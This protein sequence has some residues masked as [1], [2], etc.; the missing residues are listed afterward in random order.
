MTIDQHPDACALLV[1]GLSVRYGGFQAVEGLDLTVPTGAV[2]GL[3]GPNGAGKTSCF[4]AICGHV[5]ANAGTVTV[6]GKNLDLKSPRT[7]WLA[8]IG[9]TFQRVELFW[10]LSVR[11]HLELAIRHAEKLGR[12]PPPIEELISVVGL[13][14][15]EETLAANLPLGTCRLLELARALATGARL[16]LLDE[17]CSGLDRQETSELEAALRSIKSKIELS[18]LIVE[19]DTEFIFSIADVIFVL[20]NGRLIAHGTPGQIRSSDVVRAAY[21]GVSDEPV[22]SGVAS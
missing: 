7:A 15:L 3:I 14:G 4:N 1:R 2:V 12:T 20:D 10:T 8:G 6:D 11:E 19:H 5:S 21:L 9:R 22:I 17:P 18:L 16:L 13:V